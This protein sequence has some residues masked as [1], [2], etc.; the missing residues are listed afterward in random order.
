MWIACRRGCAPCTVHI[1]RAAAAVPGGRRARGAA[2]DV[3]GGASAACARPSR[4]LRG[5]A[6]RVVVVLTVRRYSPGRIPSAAVNVG[7]QELGAGGR[8]GARG[9]W[10]DVGG[11]WRG[12]RGAA[13]SD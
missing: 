6:R 10:R 13:P 7:A 3:A 2:H 12:L 9:T 5:A 4:A 1:G 11:G 8:V